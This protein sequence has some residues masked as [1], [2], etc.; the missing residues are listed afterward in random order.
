MFNINV[1]VRNLLII[2]NN[3]IRI[4]LKAFLKEGDFVEGYQSRQ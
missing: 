4:L 2:W 1:K 3:V